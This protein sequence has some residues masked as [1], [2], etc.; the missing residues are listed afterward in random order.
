MLF[1][2]REILKQNQKE[3]KNCLCVLFAELEFLSTSDDYSLY[4]NRLS[5]MDSNFILW[6]IDWDVLVTRF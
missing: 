4:N 1:W 5:A 2:L 6:N 3:F